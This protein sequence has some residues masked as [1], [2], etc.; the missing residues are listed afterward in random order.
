MNRKKIIRTLQIIAV[1]YALIGILFYN[2]Q[3]QLIF[4]PTVVEV[5]S[6][7]GFKQPYKE[8]WITDDDAVKT[9]L[10]QFMVA[11]S[12][13]K[14]LVLYFHGNR[15]NINRYKG[16][17]EKFTKQGYAV[18]MPDYPGFG[19]STGKLTEAALYEQAL[20]VYKMARVQYK[21]EQIIIYGKSM[22]TG[23]ASQ[24]ASVRDC[25]RLILETPYY[26]M[27]SLIGMYLW[28][29]PL[30]NILH[31]KFPSN[32]N[33]LKVTAPITIF[34]G[35][36]DGVIPYRNAVQ[37]KAVLKPVDEFITIEK[38]SHKDLNNFL[39][40]QQKMDSLLH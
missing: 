18:W 27:Q 23:V 37:L 34:H 17:V 31:F 13:Q 26:S 35:T 40:M 5:D 32:E 24:L 33:L 4:H 6:N 19:K 39:L 3:E 7:Y 10:V 30:Q 1:I 36:D 8:V 14:G 38:G 21:P 16:F 11:D 28:M 22:G 25:K 9:H 29:Y 12:M 2:F 15:D 20:Q